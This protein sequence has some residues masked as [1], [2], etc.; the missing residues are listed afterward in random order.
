VSAA[1]DRLVK[2]EA[3]AFV[4]SGNG[5]IEMVAASPAV[6]AA[7]DIMTGDGVPPE[8]AAQLAVGAGRDGRDPEAWARHFVKLRKSLRA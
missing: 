8:R 3:R 2:R 4:A 6:S 1:A 7:Y 5:T